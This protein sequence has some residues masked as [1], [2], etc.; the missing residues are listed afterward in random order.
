MPGTPNINDT[1]VR[2]LGEWGQFFDKAGKPNTILELMDQENSILDDIKFMEANGYDA[3]TTTIRNGLPEVYWR[4]LYKGIPPSK[5]QIS[6]VKDACGILEARSMIDIKMLELHQSQ[7]RAYRASE[8]RAF[9]EAMRQKLANT[10]IYGSIENNPDGFHGLDPRYAHKNAPQVIDAGGATADKCTSIWGI[11][12]GESEVHGI[13]PKDS[14]AGLK[15]KLLPEQDVYDADGNAYRAEG[16]LFTWNVGLTVR[17]WRCVVRV[18]NIDTTKLTIEKGQT[19]FVDLHRLTVRAKN[20]IPPEKRNRLIWYAN[21]DVM[22]A[23]ELQSTDSG[24][25]HLVYGDLFRSK[26]IPHIH[27]CPVRQLDAI[28]STENPLVA[29]P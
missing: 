14:P 15:H 17:D 10:F 18:C 22:T 5:S 28:L 6:Q 16:D 20:M 12:W 2:T 8:S 7:A 24:Y 19:G 23:L 13:F 21:Q 3:H 1:L 26:N 4:R 9:M 25:V 11:V 27:G 29:L